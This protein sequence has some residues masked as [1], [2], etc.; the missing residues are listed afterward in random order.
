M[1]PFCEST[2]STTLTSTPV[3]QSKNYNEGWC[4]EIASHKWIV[5]CKSHLLNKHVQGDLQIENFNQPVLQQQ[6]DCKKHTLVGYKDKL[7]QHQ[8]DYFYQKKKKSLCELSHTSVLFLVI[9]KLSDIW[10]FLVQWSF[11][12]YTLTYPECSA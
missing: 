9:K 5:L 11:H 8:G 12:F 7:K 4:D 3:R 6:R 10:P 2:G 1:K